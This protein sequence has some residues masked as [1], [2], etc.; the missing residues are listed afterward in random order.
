MI[1]RDNLFL[2]AGANGVR[3]H[4]GAIVRERLNLEVQHFVSAAALEGD[5]WPDVEEILALRERT[6]LRLGF[7]APFRRVNFFSR[8]RERRERSWRALMA[9]LDVAQRL[10]VEFVVVHSL[11]VPRRRNAFYG[12]DWRGCAGDFFGQVARE[13][14]S[15]GLRL[16]I[17]NMLEPSPEGLL[18]LLGRLEAADAGICFDVAHAAVAGGTSAAEWVEGLGPALLHMHLSDNHGVHDE[19]LALGVG[20]VDFP[21]ALAAAAALPQE[22][23]LGIECRLS[24][25]GNLEKSLRYLAPLL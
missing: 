20:L 15:R 6:G 21:G 23:S 13:A 22:I 10:S 8:N 5:V 9:G 12:R 19:H 25:P 16:A 17:E 4:R 3:L 24:P 11:Y 7:H 14:A 1:G 18:W 2:C